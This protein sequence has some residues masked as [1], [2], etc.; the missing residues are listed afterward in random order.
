MNP[1]NII[2]N[3]FTGRNLHTSPYMPF[4]NALRRSILA[5]GQDGEALLQILDTIE[6]LGGTKYINEQLQALITEY[7]K[8]AKFEIAVKAALLNSTFGIANNLV[9][10][11]V[12]NGFD[13][14]RQL[15]HKY[16][17][18]AGDV[19][20]ILIQELMVLKPVSENELDI[21]FNAIDIITDLYSK[22]GKQEDLSDK[23]VRAAIFKHIPDKIAKDLAMDL[24]KASSADDMQGII[25]VYM[26]E[27]RIGLQ[28]GILGPMICATTETNREEDTH[29]KEPTQEL[30]TEVANEDAGLSGTSINA[31][32]KGG[33]KADRGKGKGYGQCWECGGYGHP[34]RECKVYLERIGEGQQQQDI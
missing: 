7:P 25:N 29:K 31:A 3:T 30:K 15:Y 1:R 13:A 22:T 14:W 28:R 32:T 19:Q 10:Y 11:G 12:C 20:N 18:L 5:Q 9:R 8:A 17:R 2:I 4:S 33:K 27:H 34:R 23:W 6:S 24:R 16:V 21:V 26:H